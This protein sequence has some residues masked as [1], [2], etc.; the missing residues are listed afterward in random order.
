MLLVIVDEVM[1]SVEEKQWMLVVVDYPVDC[2]LMFEVIEC[3][4]LQ[5]TEVLYDYYCPREMDQHRTEKEQDSV[6]RV[7]MRN[8]LPREEVEQWWHCHAMQ[9]NVKSKI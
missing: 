4:H 1:Y 9:R 5:H 3:N 6:R 8:D 2:L 7:R